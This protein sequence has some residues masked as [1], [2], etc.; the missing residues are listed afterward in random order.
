MNQEVTITTS[1]ILR[2]FSDNMALD[3]FHTMVANNYSAH[4]LMEKHDNLTRKQF[5]CRVQSMKQLGLVGKDSG[6]YRLTFFG[7]CVYFLLNNFHEVTE[8]YHKI[9]AID[10]ILN[11]VN[12]P[13]DEATDMINNLTQNKTVR[14]LLTAG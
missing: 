9:R 2:L 10:T 6:Q 13:V 14:E 3:I 8:E 12:L 11:D 4:G 5:Y 7:K 1:Q